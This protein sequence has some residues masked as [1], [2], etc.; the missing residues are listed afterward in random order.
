MG[1]EG[2]EMCVIF[3]YYIFTGDRENGQKGEKSLK[4]PCTFDS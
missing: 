4:I 1:S 2:G 3:A